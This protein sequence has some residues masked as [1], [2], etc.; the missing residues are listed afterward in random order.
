MWSTTRWPLI[1]ILAITIGCEGP[2]GPAGPEGSSGRTGEPGDPGSI[3]EPGPRGEPGEQ[4]EQGEQG[5]PGERG[6]PGPTGPSVYVPAPGL[7][8]E[9]AAASIEVDGS[10]HVVLRARD[11]RG[12]MLPVE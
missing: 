10:L 2:I 6:E 7:T 8:L 4:G 9:V 3:G 5:E 12:Q 1:S 11:S